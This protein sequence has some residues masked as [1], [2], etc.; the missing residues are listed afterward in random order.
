MYM[1][2]INSITQA[3][4]SPKRLKETIGLYTKFEYIGRDFSFPLIRCL[5]YTER[6]GG[7]MCIRML[8]S[9]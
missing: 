2:R 5:Y 3:V 1:K 9:P 7:E 8:T 6:E 4:Y